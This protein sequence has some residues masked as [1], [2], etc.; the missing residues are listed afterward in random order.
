MPKWTKK[1]KK[2]K[3]PEAQGNINLDDLED[4]HYTGIYVISVPDFDQT[5]GYYKV[6]MSGGSMYTRLDQYHLYYPRGYDINALW[7]MYHVPSKKTAKNDQQWKERDDEA[8][9]Q[10]AQDRNADVTKYANHNARAYQAE[11]A[12]HAKLKEYTIDANT[13]KSGEYEWFG[14]HEKDIFDEI[15]QAMYDLCD[16]FGGWIIEEPANY[17]RNVFAENAM[18]T[19]IPSVKEMENLTR[20]MFLWKKQPNGDDFKAGDEFDF[21]KMLWMWKLDAADADQMDEI[22]TQHPE[23]INPYG[24]YKEKIKQGDEEH[25][26]KVERDHRRRKHSNYVD[27]DIGFSKED[28][29]ENE[30]QKAALKK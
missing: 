5:K 16:Q 3:V 1:K 17:T 11:T 4:E 7:L 12:L 15:I 9:R 27:R 29:E 25:A 24:F 13:R 10:S 19:Y 18:R 22:L 14:S 28:I 30:K 21:D 26:E 6:G 23:L 2:P 8:E 20:L